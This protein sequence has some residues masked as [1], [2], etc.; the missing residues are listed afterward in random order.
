MQDDLDFG[1]ADIMDPKKKGLHDD[2]ADFDGDDL[3]D[4]DE[5]PLFMGLSEDDDIFNNAGFGDED[6]Y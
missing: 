4:D 3:L 6:G 2:D 1:G 5:D